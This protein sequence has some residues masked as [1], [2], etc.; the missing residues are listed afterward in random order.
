[1]EYSV[2]AT[3]LYG[4]LLAICTINGEGLDCKHPIGDCNWYKQCL[5]TRYPMCNGTSSYA[6]S[7]GAVFCERFQQNKKKFSQEGQL[8][9]GNVATCLQLSLLPYMKENITMSC[10]EI[11]EVAF[12]THPACY[13]N[14]GFC[15]LGF[16]DNLELFETVA[17]VIPKAFGELTRQVMRIL[18]D[19]WTRN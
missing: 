7:F 8:W 1:M 4:N 3:L 12:S 18:W 9:I 5:Q 11:K 15:K 10:D 17:P 13:V 6:L 14:N 2:K 19:C 16:W